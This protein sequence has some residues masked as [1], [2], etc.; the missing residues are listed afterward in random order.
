MFAVFVEDAKNEEQEELLHDA[1]SYFFERELYYV[2]KIEL[3]IVLYSGKSGGYCSY[4]NGKYEIGLAYDTNIEMLLTLFHEL[5]HL[6]QIIDGRLKP[7]IY[8]TVIW[9][10][11]RCSE[12]VETIAEYRALPWEAEANTQM[13]I[14]Y[15]DY[16]NTKNKEQ[17][18]RFC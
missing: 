11:K 1:V 10:G 13:K 9:N 5:T 16:D 14:L 17:N 18:Q 3:N 8:P 4:F 7:C 12:K 2:I 6:K 15:N